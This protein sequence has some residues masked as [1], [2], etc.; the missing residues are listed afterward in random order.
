MALPAR[1]LE[2]RCNRSRRVGAKASR[3][4]HGR[5]VGHSAPVVQGLGHHNAQAQAD[6]APGG[7]HAPPGTFECGRESR[8]GPNVRDGAN[9]L[10]RGES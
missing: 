1:L 8:T 7:A 6:L 10:S 4:D 3:D 9:A 2:E 5:A